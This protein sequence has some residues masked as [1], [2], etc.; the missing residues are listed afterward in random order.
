MKVWLRSGAPGEGKTSSL[1]QWA[2]AQAA[3]GRSLRAVLQVAV[4][5]RTLGQGA[6]SYDL[7]LLEFRPD[8]EPSSRCLPGLARR[9]PEGGYDFLREAFEEAR[10][11]LTRPPL[12]E[13]IVLD[14][15]GDTELAGGGH[16]A[17][18]EDL[19]ALGMPEL[20]LV[21]GVKASALDGVRDL[22]GG[23]EERVRL[24]R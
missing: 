9:R 10:S 15:V 22:T 21:L 3:L 8:A 4:G 12:P 17:A 1:H 18:L 19:L 7:L 5:P 23:Q 11:F 20:E 24:L 2:L 13:V 14:E 6:P 16:R